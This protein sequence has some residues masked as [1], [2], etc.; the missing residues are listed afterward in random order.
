MFI[1]TWPRELHNTSPCRSADAPDSDDDDD[2][3]VAQ[4]MELDI[5]LAVGAG[6]TAI[7]DQ[8]GDG[9]EQKRLR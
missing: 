2:E 9:R 3:L 8:R 4:D 7:A 1:G 6:A 5:T